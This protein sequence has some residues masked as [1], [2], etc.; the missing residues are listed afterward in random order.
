MEEI[1]KILD[2]GDVADVLY[3]DFAKAFDKVPHQRLICKMKSLNIAGEIIAWIQAWLSGRKQRV[4]LNGQQSDLIPVPCG[5]PQESVLG[6]PLF[7]IFIDDID[8]CIE[9]LSALLLKF[10]DDTKVVKW[11]R[12][13]TNR[14]YNQ[15]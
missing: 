15:L 6:P 3:L 2:D 8:L 7:V 13:D 9:A 12:C 5:V 11:I 4:V 14:N 1:T 10:A